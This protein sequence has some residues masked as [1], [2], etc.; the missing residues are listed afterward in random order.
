MAPQGP[1]EGAQGP[2]MAIRPGVVPCLPLWLQA[3]PSAMRHQH[4][5]LSHSTFSPASGPGC[6]EHPVSLTVDLVK[7]SLSF[8]LG[9]S[10]TPGAMSE[11]SSSCST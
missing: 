8:S 10:V 3:L 9:L 4:S 7:S 5:G 2:V 6:Q 11:Y 1:G